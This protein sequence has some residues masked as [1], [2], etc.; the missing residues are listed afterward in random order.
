MSPVFTG[1]GLRRRIGDGD[2]AR[3]VVDGIDITLQAGEVAVLVG[4]SGSGKTTLAHLVSGF[5]T[6]TEGH[7]SWAGVGPNTVPGWRSVGVVPQSL[8][9]LAELSYAEQ[10]ELAVRYLPR[11]ERQTEVDTRLDQLDIGHLADRLPE[12]TSLGQQQ[13]LAVARALIA[14]PLL[15]VADEPTS[16]QDHTH[17]DTVADVLRQAAAEGSACL[18][19]SHDVILRRIADRVITM[20]D[21]RIDMP[22]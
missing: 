9:L 2:G 18:V 19:A 6:P 7:R 22:T 4:P 8:G 20:T 5:D 11:S 15:I 16:R 13:R 3:F 10:L 21:G 12:E 1:S 14:R 17:A